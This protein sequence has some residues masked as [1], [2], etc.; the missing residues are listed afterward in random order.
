MNHLHAV[1]INSTIS[2]TTI[3]LPY[4]ANI[5][6]DCAPCK[7]SHEKCGDVPLTGLSSG[8]EMC[9]SSH[10]FCTLLRQKS[11]ASLPLLFA[12][13]FCGLFHLLSVLKALLLDITDSLRR[14][15]WQD[16]PTSW[17]RTTELTMIVD[18]LASLSFLA[19]KPTC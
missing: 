14:L 13:A 12:R 11:H 17:L 5:A 2:A 18:A 9:P 3:R 4:E 7:R 10:N 1:H 8:A 19:A 6:I 15:K 16:L